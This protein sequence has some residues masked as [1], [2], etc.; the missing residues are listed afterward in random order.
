[1]ATIHWN[2]PAVRARVAAAAAVGIDATMAACVRDAKRSHGYMN[3]DGFLEASTQIVDLAAPEGPEIRG[4]WGA[5]A[6]YA[7]FVEIGTSRIGPRALEREAADGGNMWAVPATQPAD[8]VTVRQPFTILPPG[9]MPGQDDW[10]TVHRPSHGTGPLMAQRP[11]LRPA[12]D[13]EY[14]GLAARIRAA[15]EA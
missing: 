7:L 5:T 6:D 8:G 3:R 15:L 2:G 4:R 13:A 1:M 11:F 14:P 9:T 12:A 10:V